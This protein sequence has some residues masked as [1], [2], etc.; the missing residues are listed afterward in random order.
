[1]RAVIA[2]SFARIHRRN[3]VAQGIL[4]LTFRDEADY[5]R[6]RQG[7][8]WEIPDLHLALERG[9]EEL[10]VRCGEIDCE[11]IVRVNLVH[12]EREVLLAGGLLAQLRGGGTSMNVHNGHS[13]IVD[14][15]SLVTNP[16]ADEVVR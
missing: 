11:V 13:A 7:D 15:G 3:L 8:T 4:P 16:I 9:A 10:R 1:V 12:H 2:K 6:A 14:Q 5:N